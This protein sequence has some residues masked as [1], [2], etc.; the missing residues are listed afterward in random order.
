MS[1]KSFKTFVAESSLDFEI[2]GEI[3]RL[4]SALPGA[5]LLEFIAGSSSEDP[6]SM[7]TTIQNMLKASIVTEDWERWDSFTR[8]P[9][10]GVTLNVLAE[11]A[12]YVSEVLSGNPQSPVQSTD[13][14]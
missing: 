14:S 4:N 8:N 6:S 2:G 3:F 10:N 13:G 7:A 12:G 1:R 9:D 5:I 11:V